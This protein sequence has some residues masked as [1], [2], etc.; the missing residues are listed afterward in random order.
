[1]FVAKIYNK[2]D[3]NFPASAKYVGRP[4]LNGN[5]FEIGKDGSRDDVCYKFDKWLDTGENFG[6]KAATE[7]RRQWILSHLPELKG[8]DLVCWC[9]PNKCHA[10]SLAIR[11]NRD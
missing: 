3:K 9:W 2:R 1:V 6:N 7:E 8:F 10:I 4:T 11:A 5:P